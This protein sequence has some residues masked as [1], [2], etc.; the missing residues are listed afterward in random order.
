MPSPLGA[1]HDTLQDCRANAPGELNAGKTRLTNV[2]GSVKIN[3]NPVLGTVGNIDALRQA[4]TGL[5]QTG[6]LFACV[7]P[8]IHPTGDRRGDYAFLTP[9]QAATGMVDK[10]G[11]VMDLPPGGDLQA[12][13][14]LLRGVEHTGFADTLKAFNAVFPVTELQLAE[15]RAAWLATLETDKLIQAT[16]PV[17]PAWHKQDPRR[18]ERA[19]DLDTALGAQVALG[20][21]YALESVRPED[22]LAA[23]IDKKQAHV[24]QLETAWT[25]LQDVIQG[26]TGLG[27]ILTG[28][29]DSIH[30]QLN[31]ALPPVEGYKLAAMCC[32]IGT[33]EQTTFIKELLGL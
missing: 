25:A 26:G 23:L 15:R 20:E 13:F 24:T 11:D 4:M 5:L 17:H 18:H 32:W 7:H 22:E 6:G 33:D 29:R 14:L 2:A 31:E 30:R 3:T 21:G 10:L 8:Y 28:N 9:Q 16:G 1:A 19:A 27:Q 12:V